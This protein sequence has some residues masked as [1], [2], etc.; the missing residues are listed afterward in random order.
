MSVGNYYRRNVSVGNSVGFLRFS[1]SDYVPKIGRKNPEVEELNW[2]K[3][4]LIAFFY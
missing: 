2:E 4:H 1:G 3:N